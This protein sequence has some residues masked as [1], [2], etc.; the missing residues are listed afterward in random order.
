MF[1]KSLNLSL[2]SDL[3]SQIMTKAKTTYAYKIQSIVREFPDE[4][5][6]SIKVK[7]HSIRFYPLLSVFACVQKRLRFSTI[8]ENT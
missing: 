1:L 8:N 7:I 5:M 6:E 2:D 4:C 3:D